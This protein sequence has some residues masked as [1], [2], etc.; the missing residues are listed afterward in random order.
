MN[1]HA[2]GSRRVANEPYELFKGG[3]LVE[4]GVTDGIGQ[5]VIKDHQPGT[6]AYVVQLSSGAR[7]DLS[8]AETLDHGNPDQRLANRGFRGPKGAQGRA[9]DYAGDDGSL[10]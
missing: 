2:A 7:F 9:D 6:T 3:A 1:S 4:K 8:V 5:L 10:A